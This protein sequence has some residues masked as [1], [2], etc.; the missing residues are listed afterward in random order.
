[1]DQSPI[2]HLTET[3]LRRSNLTAFLSYSELLGTYIETLRLANTHI[4]LTTLK[5]LDTLIARFIAEPLLGWE[6]IRNQY[7]H[8]IESPKTLID[9]G[10]GGGAPGLPI[11]ITHPYCS[12]TLIESRKQKATFL[13]DT[14]MQ[15]SLANVKIIHDRV[16]RIAHGKGREHFEVATARALAP[17]PVTIQLLL[18]LVTVGGLVAIWAGPSSHNYMAE[19]EKSANSAGGDK[20]QFIPIPWPGFNRNLVLVTTRKI[21]SSPPTHPH[22]IQKIRQE[23]NR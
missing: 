14:K 1:M 7:N 9:V 18:P 22:T 16:E 4:N 19:C 12:T 23:F 20:P 11:A 2:S 13:E 21:R 8:S 15:L 3:L 10:S 6:Y 17:L 5:D